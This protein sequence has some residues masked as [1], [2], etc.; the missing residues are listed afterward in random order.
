MDCF[1]IVIPNL[2]VNDKLVVIEDIAVK[3]HDHVEKEDFLY[4]AVTSKAVTDVFAEDEGFI[5]HDLT[6]GKEV[7]MGDTVAWIFS[8]LDDAQKKQN[9]LQQQ[10][11]SGQGVKATKKAQKFAQE[12]NIDL[13]RIQK[14]GLITEKDVVQ[15]REEN[16]E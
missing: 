4:S 8:S 2:D 13:R 10:E 5:V 12:N 7:Q 3:S 9:E 16:K 15:F 14:K 6:D 1:A 11:P